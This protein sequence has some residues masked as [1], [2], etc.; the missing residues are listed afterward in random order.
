MANVFACRSARRPPWRLGWTSNRLV[1]G[2][3]VVELAALAA[4]LYIGPV[5]SA[6][7]HAVPSLWPAVVALL[8]A[9]AVL[10]ADAAYK[11]RR[12]SGPKSRP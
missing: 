8:A 11:K 1:V 10:G 12:G 6:L 5:A 3:V 7:D 2:A 4:F 9:P